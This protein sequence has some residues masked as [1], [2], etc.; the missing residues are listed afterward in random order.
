MPNR[1]NAVNA[2]PPNLRNEPKI[3]FVRKNFD[4]AVW[5]K[6]Y[7]VYIEKAVRCPCEGQI[8]NAY[9]S[10]Q[11][12]LGH[13][14]FFIN[15]YKTMALATGINKN[16]EYQSWS[17]ELI[18]NISISLRDIPV[19][20]LAFYDKITFY[21]K[22]GYHSEV[23]DLKTDTVNNQDFVFLSYRP[24]EI[25]D[26]W[27]FKTFAEPLI[28]LSSSEYT[29][30]TENEYVLDI[31]ITA[32]PLNFNEVISVRYKHEVQYNVIDIPHEI[33]TS[34]IKDRDG[35]LVKTE[36]PINAIA[37]KSHLLLAEIPNYDG[38]GIQD[39]SY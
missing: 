24:V 13:G 2:T 3:E 8:K 6:G 17:P 11:N 19:E 9:S 7:R 33:R 25:L 35:K 28:K 32:K 22:F 23:L 4:A 12:C 37:R 10:C 21:E 18:G 29:I 30:R 1:K 16:T 39:N 34:Q 20:A 31:D 38:T 27:I 26:V 14:F 5:L 15:P 36:L